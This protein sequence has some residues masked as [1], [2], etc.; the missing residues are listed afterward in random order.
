MTVNTGA[1]SALASLSLILAPM[2]IA[3]VTRGHTPRH[4]TYVVESKGERLVLWGDLMHVAAVQF[5]GPS[6][7]IKLPANY[8]SLR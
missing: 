8:T 3:T 1:Y 5:P 6:V 2:S 7:T 4:T